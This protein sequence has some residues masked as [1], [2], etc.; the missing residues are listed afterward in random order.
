MKL[1]LVDRIKN[2]C[3][4]GCYFQHWHKR[5]DLTEDLHIMVSGNCHA[6]EDNNGN[7]CNIFMDGEGKTYYHSVIWVEEKEDEKV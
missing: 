1:K 6:F 2:G 7:T 5:F 3:C 4:D